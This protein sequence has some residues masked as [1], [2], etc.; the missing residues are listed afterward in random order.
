MPY[1]NELI[2]RHWFPGLSVSNMVVNVSKLELLW[3][4]KFIQN[5]DFPTFF[6]DLEYVAIWKRLG[7]MLNL[8][9]GGGGD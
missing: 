7:M 8:G 6:G 3:D 4:V 1:Y 2:Y 9:R 5:D